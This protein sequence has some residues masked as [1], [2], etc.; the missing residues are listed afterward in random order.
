[1]P[2]LTTDPDAESQGHQA[3]GKNFQLVAKGEELENQ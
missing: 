3:V 2:S 1:M